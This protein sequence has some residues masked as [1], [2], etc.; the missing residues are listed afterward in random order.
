M[1]WSRA[2]FSFYFACI[3][4][5]SARAVHRR[6]NARVL[7]LKP[8]DNGTVPVP[9]VC[10]T[11][12]QHFGGFDQRNRCEHLDLNAGSTFLL[13]QWNEEVALCSAAPEG[14]WGHSLYALIDQLRETVLW[15][16]HQREPR[17]TLPQ[18]G[19]AVKSS[20]FGVQ[21]LK[22]A[23]VVTGSEFPQVTVHL[24]VKT[25]E[26][27]TDLSHLSIRDTI[28]DTV[29]LQT[30]GKVQ[31]REYQTF[32][33]DTL[34]AGSSYAVSYTAS[35]KGSIKEDLFLPAFL[36]F[37]SPSQNDINL[38]GPVVANF[39]LRI[40]TTEKVCVNHALHFAGFCVA[41]LISTLLLSF[42]LLTASCFYKKCFM[43]TP[44]HRKRRSFSV[45][46]EPEEA[47]SNASDTANED[48]A[49]ED[50][51]IDI[52]ALEDPQDMSHALDNL[53]LAS[54]LRGAMMVECVRVQMLKGVFRVLTASVSRSCNEIS[55]VDLLS[56][57]TDMQEDRKS[58]L[59]A[60]SPSEAHAERQEEWRLEALRRREELHAIISEEI[61]EAAM[62]GGTH[63]ANQ[64]LHRYY[65]CQDQLESVL[66]LF[67]ANQR[68]AL[69]EQQAQRRY[70]LQGL[71]DLQRS[72][73]D[74][75]GAFSRH[76][77]SWF[78]HIRR[79]GVLSDQH[80]VQQLE[81]AQSELQRV[82]KG[83]E[84][85]LGRERSSAHC[86]IIKTRRARIAETLCEQKREQ[87]DLVC[88]SV[89]DGPLE[90]YLMRWQT[91][92]CA[93]ST[94][95]SELIT[96]LDQEAAAHLRRVLVCVLRDAVADLKQVECETSQS[97]QE[98]GVPRWLLLQMRAGSVVGGCLADT[99]AE[100]GVRKREAAKTLRLIRSRIQII[101]EQEL[102][103]QRERRERMH[104]Y[105]RSVWESQHSLSESDLLRMQLE[106]VKSVCHLDRCLVLPHFL[107]L[108]KGC[109]TP[110]NQN[111]KHTLDHT[112]G[113]PCPI[114]THAQVCVCKDE[115]CV[116]EDEVSMCEE[117]VA[118]QVAAVQWDKAVRK[119]RVRE[120]H[121]AVLTLQALLMQTVSHAPLGEEL[122]HAIHTHSLALEEAE[123]LLQKEESEWERSM[124]GLGHN[125]L[126]TPDEEEL[127]HVNTECTITECLQEALYKR[128]QL[129]HTLTE[130]LRMEIRR[131]Q[132]MEDLREQQELKRL[133]THFDQDL[134]LVALLVKLSG[135]SEPVLQQLLCLLLPTHPEGDLQSL[136]Q[137]LAPKEGRMLGPCCHL[138]DRLRNDVISKHT[139]LGSHAHI[140]RMLKKKQKL[141]EKLFSGSH[142]DNLGPLPASSQPI[143]A[144]TTQKEDASNVVE[145]TTLEGVEC[146][147]HAGVVE[148]AAGS[149]MVEERL[150][151]VRCAPGGNL[152]QTHM[153]HTTHATHTPDTAEASNMSHNHRKRRKF[154][155]KKGAVAPQEQT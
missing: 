116:C 112:S 82:R 80:C 24:V 21:F 91:L 126:L 153:G 72:M 10:S 51:I 76:I 28:S 69:S 33:T 45:E 125:K 19:S 47:V 59:N 65:T 135:V 130:R 29:S 131:Q 123:L 16:N 11:R 66:D 35:V 85:T 84:E 105:R 94:H 139:S 34:P 74:M 108:E 133:Y 30:N 25:L 62:M 55:M 83:F 144:P 50:R 38:L 118:M 141:M 104:I 138:V 113:D 107:P 63:M 15:R 145:E 36:T 155:F 2:T 89:C 39:T 54:L 48:A 132:V 92:L 79:E 31:D 49:F 121:S 87:Q 7:T 13:S 60:H 46:V 61:E 90:D 129:T 154:K 3:L 120:T 12:G 32:S 150:F 109:N 58:Q 102:Q 73:C 128:R 149:E 143:T 40:N 122:S 151:T 71:Q 43:R 142:A 100:L 124:D 97:M 22:C 81:R 37:S 78:T 20:E 103:H 1:C 114:F 111:T 96:H 99:E 64:L 56:H 95:L 106:Y 26:G 17:H 86:D 93:H 148:V 119:N 57:V 67:I 5:C 53:E 117:R 44:Q 110:T 70:L 77:D 41:F 88:G 75:F 98:A 9:D 146:T 101:R 127:F 140:D 4:L 23:Q 134:L 147:S 6:H 14:P 152:E 27:A 8:E 42:T 137:T 115:V 18:I 68:A 136:I 52:M